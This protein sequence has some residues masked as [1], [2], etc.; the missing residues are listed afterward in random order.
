MIL[1][2]KKKFNELLDIDIDT[3]EKRSFIK[4]G[5]AIEGSSGQF[6]R[7]N[8]QTFG[9]GLQSIEFYL[10]VD[11]VVVP[12]TG[13]LTTTIRNDTNGRT[14]SLSGKDG[15]I[16]EVQYRPDRPV[17]SLTYTEEDEDVDILLWSHN[18]LSSPDRMEIIRETNAS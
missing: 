15:L 17:D 9:L 10:V 4:N 2:H 7:V 1:R 8:N 14:F 18:V 5:S 13:D 16:V 3:G 12:V 11:N 6:S